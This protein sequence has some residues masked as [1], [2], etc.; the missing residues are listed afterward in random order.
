VFAEATKED[1]I[2]MAKFDIKDGFWRMD[3]CKGE[4]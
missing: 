2:F 4:E 3:C 1:K